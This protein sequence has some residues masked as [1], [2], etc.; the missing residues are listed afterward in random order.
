MTL[1]DRPI[2][3]AVVD[4]RPPPA[5]AA[6]SPRRALDLYGCLALAVVFA[7]FVLRTRQLGV[8]SFWW[9]EAYSAVVARGSLQEI[10]A[11]ITAADFHPPL[12][13]VLFHY[14]R[15]A[16]GESEYALRFTAAAAG[17]A[18][19]ALAFAAA[20]RLFGRGG[21]L[22]ATLLFAVAPYLVY[23]STEARMFALAALLALLALHLGHRATIDGRWWPAFGAALAVGLWNY[24]YAAFIAAPVGL[25]VLATRRG[26]AVAGYLG[27]I[28]LAGLLFAPWL[29]TMLAEA[30][31]WTNPWTGPTTPG[32]VLLWTWPALL[33]GIPALELW[34]DQPIRLALLGVAGL[35]F[36]LALAGAALR[37]GSRRRAS[38]LYAA[39]AAAVPLLMMAAVALVRP[40]YHPRYAMPVEP[41]LLLLVAGVAVVPVRWLLPARFVLVA[42]V[43][44]LSGYGLYRFQYTNG[45]ARD[46]YRSAIGYV[47]AHQAPGDVAITNAPPG[48]D[49]YYRG[50]MP[51][52]EFPTAPYDATSIVRRLD[53]IAH[54]HARLWYVT[55]DLRPADPEGFVDGQLDSHARLVDE[56]RFGQLRVALFQLADPPGFAPPSPHPLPGLRFGDA[57]VLEGFGL[58]EAPTPAGGR[59]QLDL[60]WRV[61]APPEADYGIWA[62]LKDDQGFAWGRQDHQP[63]DARFVLSSQWQVGEEV[64]THQSIPVEPGTPPGR[65]AI[66]VGVYRL[67]NLGGLD[68]LDQAGTKLGP[69]FVVDNAVVS[70][71]DQVPTDPQLK[72]PTGQV[73]DAVV[74]AG[75]GLSQTEVAAGASFETTLLW[76][77]S[78]V[79]GPRERVLRLVGTDGKVAAER[80]DPTGMGRYPADRWRPGD[81]VRDQARFTVPPTLPGGDYQVWVGL[82]PPGGD[83]RGLAIGHLSVTGIPRRFTLPPIVHPVDADFGDGVRLRGWDVARPDPGHVRVTLVWQPSATPS[84]DYRVFNHLLDAGEKIVAQQDGVPVKWSRPTTSWLAGEAIEDVYEIALPPNPPPLRLRVGVYEPTGGQRL[85]LNN[86]DDHLDLGAVP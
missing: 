79:P 38:L 58:N 40:I 86:G 73:D 69:S 81:L 78:A 31:S 21:G 12:H 42:L 44:G 57:L 80:R 63:R 17:T 30:A 28:A 5:V 48:F 46:D 29:P 41:G 72:G 27:S 62:R 4:R 64:T 10:V 59:V 70:L 25:L 76:R 33:T 22:L 18:T 9:D 71:G 77:A 74:L 49:Y 16:A 1:A 50:S 45:L 23:Y 14:W 60:T 84:R 83:P 2:A 67:G 82:S 43:L 13:Y 19:I 52:V 51:H 39:G 35:A 61:A 75:S 20:R 68:V 65:Y 85:H 8:Q 3:A 55:H 32:R 37:V 7:G 15:I 6:A 56:Q 53:Q 36:G 47:N 11:A 34:D 26:R 66:E 24:Y 54:G